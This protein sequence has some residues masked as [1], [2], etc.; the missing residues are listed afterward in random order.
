MRRPAGQPNA[1]YSMVRMAGVTNYLL[2]AWTNT[3]LA[4]CETFNLPCANIRPLLLEP[5]DKD[6]WRDITVAMWSKPVLT[7][8][9]LR[10]GYV[11]LLSDSDVAFT[12][13]PLFELLTQLAVR[14]HADGAFQE[15]GTPRLNS[16]MFLVLPN[17]RGIQGMEIWLNR[18]S[19]PWRLAALLAT[20][21]IKPS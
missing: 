13:K 4:D 8:R 16:G 6:V 3:S 11:V 19:L 18:S 17:E 7:L 21:R 12:T 2:F 1:I 9:A 5:I 15:E 14:S 20:R 10:A